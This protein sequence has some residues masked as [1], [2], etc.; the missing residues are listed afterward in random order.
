MLP[1]LAAL[2]NLESPL[3]QMATTPAAA[4]TADPTQH[5]LTRF[6]TRT[7]DFLIALDSTNF[8]IEFF[9]VVLSLMA[10]VLLGKWLQHNIERRIMASPPRSIDAGFLT[11]PLVLLVPG[12]MLFFLLLV[13]LCA[14]SLYFGGDFAGGVSQ[15]AYA[16][17]LMKCVML[18]VRSRPIAYFLAVVIIINA[19]LHALRISR[20]VTGFLDSIAFDIGKYHISVL[21]IVNGFIIFVVVFWGAGLLSRTLESY[22]QRSTK[23]GYNARELTVKFFRIFLYFVAFMV[24]LSALGIDLTAFAVFG[25][26]VGVGIGLGLQKLTANFVSGVA[27]LMEKSIKI[28]DLIEVGGNTGWVR[29]M[30]MRY[31]LIETFDGREIMIPN[32][33]LISTRVINWTL[34]NT[35]ARV[36][37][38]IV[39]DSGCDAEKAY[40]LL[41]QSARE[42]KL[43]L[44]EPAPNCWLREITGSGFHFM[45]TFWISDIKEGRNGPQ[46]DVLFIIH[47][48]FQSE[49]ITLAKVPN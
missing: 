7:N 8:Y 34:N 13:Q 40:A 21:H 35:L 38:N 15:L 27:M 22:L 26:A 16:Y 42:H 19:A 29:K 45:L 12:L 24:T 33:E 5:L 4:V 18:V 30:N 36:E 41:L 39:V 43:C 11:K 48:K 32:E 49:S 9:L 10:A 1:L 20:S 37:I 14:I 31:A 17:F 25:G 23:L 46:S 6:S 44:K 47:K 2:D 3:P 28:G